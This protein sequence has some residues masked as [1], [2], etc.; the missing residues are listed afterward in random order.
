MYIPRKV[1]KCNTHA[2]ENQTSM[3]RKINKNQ[4]TNKKFSRILSDLVGHS[5][6]RNSKS[7]LRETK[8][9]ILKSCFFS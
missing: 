5:C 6:N 3:P 7:M 9:T 4:T 1:K 2:K 8:Y